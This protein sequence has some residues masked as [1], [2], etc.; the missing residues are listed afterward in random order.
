[1]KDY[2]EEKN[3]KENAKTVTEAASGNKKDIVKINAV[4]AAMLAEE[5]LRKSLGF[6]CHLKGPW[7]GNKRPGA[8]ILR[9]E[10]TRFMNAGGV[11]EE[12]EAIKKLFLNRTEASLERPPS[13]SELPLKQRPFD[14]IVRKLDRLEKKHE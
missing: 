9:R 6:V 8:I 13:T 14:R 4:Q 7:E 12:Q 11:D 2:I 5:Q 10:H 1:M 3:N